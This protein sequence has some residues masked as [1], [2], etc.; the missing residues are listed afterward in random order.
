MTRLS[1]WDQCVFEPWVA[2]VGDY[3]DGSL[4]GSG[5]WADYRPEPTP[6]GFAEAVVRRHRELVDPPPGRVHC[7]YFLIRDGEGDAAPVVGFLALRHELTDFLLNVG[8][9]IGYSVVPS[10]RRE[11]IAATALGL[12]LPHAR[13]LG[14]AR[15]LV[16][17]DVDNTGSYRT[18]E[19]NGGVMEDVREGKRRYWIDL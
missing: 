12:A 5:F 6:A 3:G 11:G 14:L 1:S 8:G 4:D 19:R 10:R 9:N 17:C 7:T 16:T 15:V 18:I 13:A 2:A